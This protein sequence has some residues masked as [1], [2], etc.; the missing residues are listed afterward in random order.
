[1]MRVSHILGKVL[2]NWMS[3]RMSLALGKHGVP[4]GG[5]YFSLAPRVS[6]T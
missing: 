4:D 6:A 5:T 1:M 2:M 3:L